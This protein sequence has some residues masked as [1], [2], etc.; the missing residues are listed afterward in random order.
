MGQNDGNSN[1]QPEHAVTVSEYYLDTYEVT[2]GRFR[3]YVEQY[4]GTKPAEGDGA[5]PLIVGSGW[6]AAW[7]SELA[8]DQAGLQSKLKCAQFVPNVDG[9]G[10]RQ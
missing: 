7:D 3:A 9:H 8:V 10:G 6:Q 1:E 4:D 2:V 5:H